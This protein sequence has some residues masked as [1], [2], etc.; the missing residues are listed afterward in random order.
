MLQLRHVD[1]AI[2]PVDALHLDHDMIVEDVGDAARYG[3]YR[4]RS[5]GRPAG[6]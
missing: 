1:V 2:D 4:L 6:D 5:D 3:H